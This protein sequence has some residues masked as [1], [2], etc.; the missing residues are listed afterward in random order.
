MRTCR[1][2]WSITGYESRWVAGPVDNRLRTASAARHGNAT[3]P[4]GG[5][6]EEVAQRPM[7]RYAASMASLPLTTRPHL[8]ECHDCG[9]IQRLPAMPANA[10]A[11]CPRCDAHLRHTRSDP[12]T[13]PLALNFTA[14]LLF[15]I[16]AFWTLLSVSTAGQSRD[17][18]LLSGPEQMR[19]FGL[20]ELSVVVLITTFVAPL[21]RILCMIAV[22][23]GLRLPHRPPGIRMVFAWI[24]HLRPWSMVE[25]FLL[26]LFVAYVR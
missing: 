22:L 24:E 17:A 23:V 1:P 26:G 9:T 18:D 20:W 13:P 15:G 10:R 21:A 6:F 19:S 25:I 7:P 4:P 14:L 11:A 8:L 16:G 2:G 12:F 3:L 5:R